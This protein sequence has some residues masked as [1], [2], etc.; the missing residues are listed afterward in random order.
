MFSIAICI[1]RYQYAYGKE[2]KVEIF[3]LLPSSGIQAK[4]ISSNPN[5]HEQL[6]KISVSLLKVQQQPMQYI[7]LKREGKSV[8]M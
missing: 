6:R 3:L 4:W 1:L 8:N 5:K 7:C 2:K